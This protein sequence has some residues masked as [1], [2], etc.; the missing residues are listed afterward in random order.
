MAL[1]HLGGEVHAPELRHADL[2][3]ARLRERP[4][5]VVPTPVG[6]PLVGALVALRVHELVGLR[7]GDPVD[8]LLD[9]PPGEVPRLVF[10]G[11]LVKR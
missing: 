11:V 2:H 6:L 9:R 10:E 3:L 1:D 7:I 4:A 8:G 5:A